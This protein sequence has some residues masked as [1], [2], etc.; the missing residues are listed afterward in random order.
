MTESKVFEIEGEPHDLFL[1][2]EFAVS[3]SISFNNNPK[4]V[5]QWVYLSRKLS[6]VIQCSLNA[7]EQC[8]VPLI[9]VQRSIWSFTTDFLHAWW[10]Q[11][12]DEFLK[13]HTP[14]KTN[15]KNDICFIIQ[16]TSVFR[17]LPLLS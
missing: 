11:S 17:L 15:V 7:D 6:E 10:H 3:T 1:L 8:V 4:S 16:T 14:Q 12:H 9:V 13:N 2:F 5:D